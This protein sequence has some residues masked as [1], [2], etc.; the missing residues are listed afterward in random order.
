MDSTIITF[1]GGNNKKATLT[2]GSDGNK[3][4]NIPAIQYSPALIAGEEKP[5]Y[6][7]LAETLR[8][9]LVD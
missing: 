5:I 4:T 3:I 6:A 7:K 2:I 9:K 1:D 8:A